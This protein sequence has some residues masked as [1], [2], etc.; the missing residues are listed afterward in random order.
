[1]VGCKSLLF[2]ISMQFAYSTLQQHQLQYPTLSRV[3]RDYLAIPGS[4]TSCERA[5]SS[6][7]LIGS[8]HR[9]S[10]TP[11]TFEAIQLVKSAF[12]AGDL[13]P[14]I[15]TQRYLFMRGEAEYEMD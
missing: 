15:Q 7:G 2:A 14:A 12:K 13:S 3:A 1:M 10:L 6:A 4:S 8:N 11:D 9:L 5:F